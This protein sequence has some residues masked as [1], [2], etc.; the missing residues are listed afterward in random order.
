MKIA[1]SGK[2][3]VG[4]TT[5]ASLLGYLY[6]NEGKKVFLVDADPSG[7][8][9]SSL[10][11]NGK[12]IPISE[13]KELIEQ[14]T[15]TK[16]DK[17]GGIFKINPKVNDIP[18]LFSVD[19][20]GIKLLAIGGVKKGGEGCLCPQNVLIKNLVAEIVLYRDEVVILD[21]EPGVEH[22]GRATAKG[23]N[24]I[25]IVVE[26]GMRSIHTG[27]EIKRL[28]SDI[29]IERIFIVGN[30]IRN[31]KDSDII[32]DSIPSD[33]P[34]LGFIFYNEELIEADLR[35]ES[36][37]SNEEILEQVSKIKERLKEVL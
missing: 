26:P 19:L 31:L 16:L 24:A 4:K 23:V 13:M 6:H 9:A 8:I 30:K 7:N 17:F 37:V 18:E 22:L 34:I 5:L 36:I 15:E 10:G 1:I 3:G 20:K 29:G 14:R 12:I 27:L 28:A 2:G 35:M 32:K 33:L 11:Y 21:M 25:I